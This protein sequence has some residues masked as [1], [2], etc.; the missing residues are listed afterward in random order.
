MEEDDDEGEGKV[1]EEEEV[2]CLV[3]LMG[4]CW[5]LNKLFK[6]FLLLLCF[7]LLCF[8]FFCFL[9]LWSGLVDD[10][11]GFWERG[12]DDEEEA[13]VTKEGEEGHCRCLIE[14]LTRACVG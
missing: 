11:V 14:G 13:K 12:M 6:T 8:L 2:V 10:S 3:G 9:V 1:I 5:W 4:E 7:L